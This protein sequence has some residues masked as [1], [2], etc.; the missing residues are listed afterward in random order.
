M[1]TL[2]GRS[3]LA[4]VGLVVLILLGSGAAVAY[5][6]GLVG[7]DGTIHGCVSNATGALRIV[8]SGTACTSSEYPLSWSQGSPPGIPVQ[9]PATA[10]AH[11]VDGTLDV[12]RSVGVTSWIRYPG[13]STTLLS[14][15]CLQLRFVP[16]S[17]STS[18]GFGGSSLLVSASLPYVALSGEKAMGLTPCRNA[19][20]AVVV[21][22]PPG[23][24]SD[25]YVSLTR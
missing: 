22:E 10:Y 12:A 1:A 8:K 16:K 15:Y 9:L 14:T 6:T 4:R 21:S 2:F 7:S 13:T 5:A 24:P 25:F 17:V 19:S 3:G 20:A 11:F 23:R 18:T